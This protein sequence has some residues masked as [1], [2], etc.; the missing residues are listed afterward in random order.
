MKLLNIG[1]GST[2]HKDW[3][4]LDIASSFPDVRE[5]DIRKNLPSSDAEYDVCYSSH[6]IEHLHKNK[7]K[8]LLSECNRILKPQGIL[9]IVVPDLEAIVRNYLNTLEQASSGVPEMQANY[10]WMML[11]LYDQTVRSFSEGEMGKFL[12]D[13]DISSKNFVSSRIGTEAE[14]YWNLEQPRKSLGEKL[15]SRNIYR[16]FQLMRV[17]IAKFLVS[18]VAGN[19]AMQ[20]FEEGVFRNS[21][22]I[23]R[24]MY[25]RYS[26]KLLLERSG[27]SDVRICKADESRISNFNSYQL[28]MIND[29][30]RKPDSLFM[31]AIKL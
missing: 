14:S 18:V 3:D 23:H 21:G 20:S 12:L 7:A 9:R 19:E 6:L 4:N 10:D 1:C 30:V 31:E 5:Y 15:T 16:S 28:D 13:R 11:E 24:W 26:L 25:D 8:K 27:F 22:E 17:N 29:K 2:F